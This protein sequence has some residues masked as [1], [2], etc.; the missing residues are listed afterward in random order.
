MS[1]RGFVTPIFFSRTLLHVAFYSLLVGL[2][3]VFAALTSYSE[4]HAVAEIPSEIHAG[5]SLVL[6]LLLVFRTN[7][8]YARWWEART[9][10]GGLVNACRN[11]SI[12]ISR[13]ARIDM[14]DRRECHALITTF[15]NVL[16]EHLREGV[17]PDRFPVFQGERPSHPP[18]EIVSRI[19]QLIATWKQSERIDGDELRVIDSEAQELLDICGGCERI[20]RTRIA[21]SYRIFARQCVFLFLVTFPWGI[22]AD[23][24]FWTIPMTIITAYFMIGLETVAE[25]IEEPFGKDEDDLNLEGLCDTIDRSVS[26]IFA[27]AVVPERVADEPPMSLD[28]AE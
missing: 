26:E 6:G 5:L 28:I 3:S 11:L 16:M 25:H 10:W 8:A 4:Y 18:G 13:L 12:K 15:P 7:T 21:R 2:Y 9:L 19:Y 24:G 17:D 23:F 20:R 1:E 14:D 27:R 22:S